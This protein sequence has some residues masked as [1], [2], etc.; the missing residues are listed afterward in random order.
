MKQSYFTVFSK[1]ADL[2][3]RKECRVGPTASILRQ[4]LVGPEAL[5]VSPHLTVLWDGCCYFFYITDKETE[6]YTVQVIG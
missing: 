6:I 2:D 3:W 1:E 4:T 5:P